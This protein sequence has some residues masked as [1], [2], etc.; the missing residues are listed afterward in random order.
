LIV[1]P[2]QLQWQAQELGVLIHFNLATFIES[3]GC[4]GQMVPD[5]S[6]FKPSLL[7]TDNWAQTMIDFGAQY[8]VLVAKVRIVR[9][10][11]KIACTLPFCLIYNHSMLVV[12]I[13]LQL[14]SNF[15]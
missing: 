10:F 8:A 1:A 9:L 4:E 15:L 5:V 14:M 11:F 12:F 6:L 2:E 7:N 13:W 3:D